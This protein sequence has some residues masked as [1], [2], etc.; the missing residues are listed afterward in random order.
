MRSSSSLI[1]ASS[2]SRSLCVVAALEVDGREQ[3]VQPR[4]Q[5]P[6]AVPEQAHRRRDQDHPDQRHV[7]QDRDGQADA[8]HL[9]HDVGVQDEGTEDRD[10]DERRAGDHPRGRADTLDDRA[11]GLAVLQVLLADPAEQEHLVVHRQTEQDREHQHRCQ[12]HD[13]HGLVHAD[14]VGA[15]APLEDGH[16]HAVRRT[17]AEHVEQRG[18]ERDQHRPEH[19]HQHQERQADDGCQEVRHPLLQPRGDVLDHRRG[20]GDR[21]LDV[22][23]ADGCG[24]DVAC[25]A[26]RADRRSSRPAVPWSGVRLMIARSFFGEKVGSS[27]EATPL[28]AAMPSVRSP[29][30]AAAFGEPWVSTTTASGPLTPAPYLSAIRSYALRVVAVRRVV[31]GVG[32]AEPHRERRD[33]EDRQDD[34]GHRAVAH[35]LGDDLGRPPG[36]LRP[37]VVGRLLLDE[38]HPEAVDPLAGDAEQGGQQGDGGDHHDGDHQCRRPAHHRHHRDAGDLQAGDGEHDRGAGEQHRQTGGGVGAAD[39]LGHRRHPTRG[40]D[41][42]GPG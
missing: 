32:E 13:R 30:T 31:A 42:G 40:S 16:D 6:G 33:G 35:R 1:A 34:G 26:A 22:G 19:Q 5:P 27:T 37:R 41:G 17:D 12:R 36:R 23:V 28:S 14:Q 10:H 7:Q 4:R 3:P 8:E 2:A 29:I 25:G 20:A 15:P 18:L 38:R 21:R 11:L 24:D 39:R 9:G